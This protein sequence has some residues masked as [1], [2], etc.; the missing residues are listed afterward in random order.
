M[1]KS[2]EKY[3][4]EIGKVCD[5][6]GVE[7]YA[8]GGYVRD[9]LAGRSTD[10]IDFV[11]V[12]DGPK[13]AE[14]AMK[15][16]RGHGFVVYS[17]FGTASFLKDDYKFEFVTARSETYHKDSRNPNV[18][19][20][21]LSEDLTRRD[22]TVNAMAMSVNAGTFGAISDPFDG[23]IDLDKK[24]LRTPLDPVATFDDDP[25][26][27][28]RAV[29]FASQLD[30][31]IEE[32]A[33]AAI[34]QMRDRLSII[35][36]ERITDEFLKILSHAK[37]SI[38][39]IL[40]MKTGILEIIFPEIEQL[41]GVEQRDR[42]HHKDVFDHTMKVVDNVAA[43]SD[44]PILRFIA[45]VHDIGKPYTKRFVE[46]TGWTFHG[47]ELVGARML[48][49]VC[50]RLKLSNEY[51]K[52]SRKLT[53]L[54]MRPIHLTS[55]EVTDS[56]V[57]RLLVLAGEDVDD[58]ML[59]CRAD[60][61]SGNPDRVKKHLHNFDYVMQ[62][63][64]EVEEKDRMRAFQSPVRGDEIMSI[65]D[66]E[67]GPMVGKLKKIIEEAILDGEIPNEYEAAKEYLLRIKHDYID[68][69]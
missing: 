19:I 18:E 44:D 59:F 34:M 43:V 20:A 30:F 61:T 55:E 48:H 63:M 51:L 37:P 52:Y 8:V 7:A 53:K 38:G 5:K 4:I 67:P 15:A 57:R 17:K 3:L 42:Y 47:H 11:V 23:R 35:S 64:K 29:R 60:I 65:C 27:I 69:N 58:L 56:A 36:Q 49:K 50:R 10:E 40:L 16:L 25:L 45:L 41:A 39:L 1:S 46:G 32:S 6:T 66:L 28:M 54:H 21:T 9:S 2:L 22:F 24:I 62:R 14:N 31:N 68:K 26:R 12:G 13:L 33:L